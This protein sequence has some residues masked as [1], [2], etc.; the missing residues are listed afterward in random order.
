VRP[1][2]APTSAPTPLTGLGPLGILLHPGDKPA[3]WEGYGFNTIWRP[4]NDPASD[5]FLELNR[6]RETLSFSR[7]PGEIP[8]RGL[9]QDSIT[10]FGITYLDQISDANVLGIEGNHVGLHFEPGIWA[11]VPAT[12]SPAEPQ[13]VVR[14]ASIPHGTAIIAQGTIDPAPVLGPPNISPNSITPFAIGAPTSLQAFQNESTLANNS[15]FTTPA[16]Q[17]EGV[18]QDMVDNPNSLLDRLLASVNVLETTTL[19]ISTSPKPVP[20]GGIVN[21]AFLSGAPDASGA[22]ANALAADTTATIWIMKVE[23]G[24]GAFETWLQYSQV[25]LLNFGTLSWPHVTVGSLVLQP[26]KSEPE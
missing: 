14:M 10:M 4:N 15:Q 12:T 11:I 18:T 8:N 23:T 21:T 13:T 25:V 16:S 5:H 17:R 3:T 22:S 6:T 7:I 26:F 24:D 20:G 1:A 19:Q 2:I 9:H